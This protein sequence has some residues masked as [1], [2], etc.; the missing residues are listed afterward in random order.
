MTNFKKQQ[1][2]ADRSSSSSSTDNVI[3][4]EDKEESEHLPT[5][6]RLD[7][8]ETK[9]FRNDVRKGVPQGRASAFIIEEED[10]P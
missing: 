10:V 5:Q 8:G 7:P 4:E 6:Q 9:F 2:F 1:V 3:V